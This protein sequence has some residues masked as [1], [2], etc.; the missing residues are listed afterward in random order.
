MKK[1]VYVSRPEP[2]IRRTPMYKWLE[3]NRERENLSFW[4]DPDETFTDE[5]FRALQEAVNTCDVHV[6]FAIHRGSANYR[7]GSYNFDIEVQSS[8]FRGIPIVVVQMRPDFDAVGSLT[9]DQLMAKGRVRVFEM[10]GFDDIKKLPRFIHSF[11]DDCENGADA[12]ETVA[13]GELD[14]PYEGDEPYIFVSYSH[15]DR[16]KVYPVIAR[17]QKDGYRVWYDEGIH[18]ASQWDEFIAAHIK[19]CGYMLAFIS[20]NYVES[21][22]CKDEINFARDLNKKRLLVYLE[23]TRLPLGMA[24]RLKRLQSINRFEYKTS[25]EFYEKLVSADGLDRMLDR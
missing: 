25:I 10:S 7:I 3:E 14:K 18:A 16:D 22:N 24:M 20:Q 21:S 2:E 13:A 6:A 11:L 19:D 4:M 5:S 15:K 23:K 12:E 1:L 8:L 9:I 17:L